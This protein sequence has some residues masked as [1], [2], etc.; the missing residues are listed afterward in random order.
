MTLRK[1]LFLLAK[2]TQFFL[3]IKIFA[4]DFRIIPLI[5]NFLQS[6]KVSIPT[7]GKSIR[8]SCFLLGNLIKRF[9]RFLFFLIEYINFLVPPLPSL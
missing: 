7:V 6:F 1:I 4:L 9:S 2:F 8:K 5:K 3:S